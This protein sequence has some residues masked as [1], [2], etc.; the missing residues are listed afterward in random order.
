MSEIKKVK[1]QNI[2]ESQ[3]PEFLNEE[4]PLFKE[5]LEQYYLSLEYDTGIVNLAERIPDYKN[6]ENIITNEVLFNISTPCV[7]SSELTSFSQTIEVNHTVGFPERWGLLKIDDEIITY[8]SKTQNAFLGCQRGFSGLSLDN[9]EE[10]VFSKTESKEH[11]V[12][13]KVLNIS[14]Q[15]ASKLFD[16][17]RYQFLPGFNKNEFA[18]NLNISSILSY[19][20]EFYRTKGTEVSY[21]VLFTVLFGKDS[22]IIKPI[23]YMFKASS[24]EYLTT[25]NILVENIF[26]KNVFD[27]KGKTIFQLNDDGVLSSASVYNVEFRG[28]GNKEFYEL[29]LDPESVIGNLQSTKNTF[30]TEPSPIGS[31]VINVDSTLGFSIASTVIVNSNRLSSPFYLNYKEKT[32]NQFHQVDSIPYALEYGDSIIQSNLAYSYLDD[33]TTVQFRICNSISNLDTEKTY[34]L[35]VDDKI[36]VL[37]LGKSFDNKPE[38]LNWDYN[39]ALNGAPSRKVSSINISGISTLRHSVSDVYV[40]RSEENVYVVSTG[41]P[42]YLF[43]ANNRKFEL[44]PLNTGGQSGIT[45]SIFV[46]S[47]NH[48]LETGERLY[49]NGSTN[50]GIQTGYYFVTKNS[51]TSLSLSFSNFDV[52]QKQYVN[53]NK[54]N[55][56]LNA[57]RSGYEDTKSQDLSKKVKNQ[58]LLKKI[59][60]VKRESSSSQQSSIGNKGIGILR[61]GVELYS[62]TVLDE[63]IY[64]GR[65]EDISIISEGKDYDVINYPNLVITS[66]EGS[67]ASAHVNIIGE[68]K[69]VKVISPGIGFLEKP[70]ISIRGGNGEGAVLEA[71]FVKERIVSDFNAFLGI[72]FASNRI[73]FLNTHNF[74]D[75]EEII[76]NNNT[77][78]EIFPLRKDSTYFVNAISPNTLTLHNNLLDSL[79]GINTV[80]ITGISTGFH[81]LKSVESKNTINKIYVKDGGNGYSNKFVVINSPSQDNIFDSFNFTG[82]NIYDNELIVKNHT[83]KTGDL[84]YYSNNGTAISGITSTKQYIVTVLD[85]ERFKLSDAGNKNSNANK[86]D[87]IAQKYVSISGV[88]TG[89][90][91]FYY[92]PVE[93]VVE[94]LT[95]I[96]STAVSYPN[97]IPIVLGSIES[98][99]VENPGSGYGSPTILNFNKPP[100]VEV[101]SPTVPAILKPVLNNGSIIDVQIIN[102]GSGYTNDIYIEVLGSGQYAELIPNVVD[103]KIGSVLI[104]STGVGYDLKT[105]LIIRKRGSGAKFFANI[106]EWTVNQVVK[107]KNILASKDEGQGILLPSYNE[108]YGLEYANF[109]PP[110]LLRNS[111]NDNGTAHSPILGWS[112]DGNPIYGPFGYENVNGSG[113][114]KKLN[115]G[116]VL[117]P[118]TNLINSKLRPQFEEGY[119]VQDYQYQDGPDIDLDENNGRFCITPDYP[120]GIY[121]YF[122]STVDAN[123]S[124]EQINDLNPQYPYIIGGNFKNLP[125]L[126]NFSPKFNQL[127]ID[128]NEL[129]LI[130][131]TYQY[132]IGN[133]TYEI[134]ENIDNVY[135]QEYN[136]RKV[137]S[138]SIDDIEVYESGDNY[139]VGDNLLID[140]FGTDGIGL[141]ASVGIIKGREI[142]SFSVG[143]NTFSPVSF[144]NFSTI[145]VGITTSPHGLINGEK[146]VISA[147][148]TISAS[149]L[150]GE[151]IVSIEQKSTNV[152][153]DVPPQSITGVTT[154]IQVNDVIGYEIDNYVKINNETLR[155]IDIIPKENKLIVNRSQSFTGIHTASISKVI[156]LPNKFTFEETGKISQIFRNK[157]LY[158]NPLETVGVGTTNGS[159][160]NKFIGIKTEF[161]SIVASR[162]SFVAINTSMIKVGDYISG[163]NIPVG[164]AVTSVGIGSIGIS[165]LHTYNDVG[166]TTFVL[167]VER[168]EYDNSVPAKSIYLPKHNFYTG[169]ELV[170][171]TGTP[172]IGISVF[173]VAG[174]NPF[175]L[176]NNQV[177]YAV[178]YGENYLGIS[179]IGFTSTTGI[180]TNYNSLYFAQ[181]LT[182]AGKDHSLSTNYPVVTANVENYYVSIQ[183]KDNHT[184]VSNDQISFDY[185][186]RFTEQVILR[187]DSNSKKVTSQLIQFDATS[188]NLTTN[189]IPVPENAFNTGDKVIYYSPTVVVVGGLI[190][191]NTYYV[192]KESKNKIK[193]CSSKFDLLLG[194]EINLTSVGAEPHSFAK[195]N[196]QI[197]ITKGNV[198]NFVIE[199][200]TTMKLGLFKDQGF[201]IK[202]NEIDYINPDSTYSLD[203]NKTTI[204]DKLYYTLIPQS[205]STQNEKKISTDPEVYGGNVITILSNDYSLGQYKVSV[206]SDKEFKINL[207]KK[208]NILA[209]QNVTDIKYTTNSKTVEGPIHDIK[210]NF[211]GRNYKKLPKI[212]GI[213]SKNGDGAVLL[214]V[215]GTIG[216]VDTIEAVKNSFDYPTDNTLLPLLSTPAVCEITNI[217]RIKNID[218]TY[219]GKNYNVPPRLKVIG[220]DDI[221][222]SAK[223]EGGSVVSVN[224]DKNT[225]NLSVPLDIVSLRNSNGYDIE[226]ITVGVG[227][228]TIVL[229][230]INSDNQVYPLINSGYGSTVVEFPFKVGDEIFIEKCRIIESDKS[231]YNSENYDNKFFRVTGIST[232]NYTVTFATDGVSNNFGTYDNTFGYGYVTKKSD[233]ATFKM[234]LI[235]DLSYFS[236]EKV[237]STNFEA[238][239]MNNGWDN[240]INELRMIDCKGS[241][242]D[243]DFLYGTKSKLNGKVIKVNQYEIFSNL[244]VYRDKIISNQINNS[245]TNDYLIRTSD[246]NYYQ[247]F[248]YS[249]KSEVPYTDW[250]EYIKALDHPAGFKEFSDLNI[251]SKPS[252]EVF[253]SGIG[254]S[255][256]LETKTVDLKIDT[257]VNID[258]N[259]SFYTKN[260]FSLV[261]EDNIYEDGSIENILIGAERANVVGVGLTAVRGVSLAPYIIN[262]TN[263]VLSIDDISNQFTGFTTTIGGKVVG[264]TSFK[265]KNN[266]I[267][268]FYRTFNSANSDV[269]TLSSNTIF[270]E[271]HN[272]QTGQKLI[273]DSKSGTK[274]GI[275]TTNLV[276]S[277]IVVIDQNGNVSV[278][279]TD[280][281]IIMQVGS[282]IGSAIYENGYNVGITTTISG[283]SSNAPIG[284][285]YA[286]FGS[287]SPFIPSQALTGIG[288][289]AKFTVLITY[290][291]TGSPLS[292]SII[293]RDGGSGYAVG[294]RVSIAGTYFY[295][296]NPANNLSFFVSKVSSTKVIGAANNVYSGVQG[297]SVTGVGTGVFFTVT[298]GADGSITKTTVTAGGVG[299]ALTDRIRILGSS[300]GGATPQDDYLFSPTVLG[301]NKLPRNV[302]VD[303]INNN[304]FKLSGISSLRLE[305]ELDLVSFG[306][307]TQSFEYAH[308][309]EST[310][311]LIDNIIQSP[312]SRRNITTTLATNVGIGSTVIYVSSGINSISKLDKLKINE[313]ILNVISVGIN[314]TNSIEVERGFLGSTPS[315]HSSGNLVTTLRGDFRIK[316]DVVYFSEAPYGPIGNTPFKINS[317]FQ[318]RVFSRSFDSL[319]YP[320]DQNIIL[321]DISVDFTGIAATNFVLKQNNSPVVGLFTD[322]NSNGVD[323]NNN[324]F[325]LINNVSQI[326]RQDFNIDTPSQ[327]TIRFISGVPKAG[328]IVSLGISS[329]F[330]YQTLSGAAATVSVSAAGT[331]S[332]VYLNGSGSGYRIAPIISVASTVGSGAQITATIGAGGTITNLSIANPGSGYTT[333][334][335]T[336]VNIPLPPNYSDLPLTYAPGNSGV[337]TGAKISVQVGTGSSVIQ[338]DIEEPGVGYKVG[339]VLIASGITTNP[340]ATS[341]TQF[342]LTVR[343]V[344]TDKFSGFYPGQFI[345]FED[346]S[347]FFNGRKRKFTLFYKINNIPEVI[348]LRVDDGGDLSL[349]KNL[350]VFFND[351]LQEPIRAYTFSGNRIIFTEPPKPNSKC[352]ILYYRGS[353]LDVST[354]EPTKTIKSGDGVQIIENTNDS[355]D[356]SQFERVVKKINSTSD[357]DTFTYDNVGI[358][359]D[360]NAPRPLR[361]IK[362]TKDRLINGVLYSKER[363]S[364]KSRIHPSTIA[365]K[366]I[367]ALDNEIY[368]QNAFPLFSDIDGLEEDSRDLKIVENREISPC[369]ATAFASIASSITSITIKDNGIGYQN[370]TSPEF[371][372]SSSALTIRDPINDWSP[373]LGISTFINLNAIIINNNNFYVA[374]GSQ[375]FIGIS[376]N[377]EKWSSNT[378][379]ASSGITYYSVGIT[380]TNRLI[381]VGSNGVIASS[382]GIGTTFSN[383]TQ[384]Q[385]LKPSDAIG[386]G[387]E[388]LEPDN[389]YNSTFKS[390]TYSKVLD[391]WSAVGSSGTAFSG[392]G[393]GTTQFVGRR[394]TQQTL[395][396]VTNNGFTFIVVG[397]SGYIGISN[398]ASSWSQRAFGLTS[399][400]LNKVIWDGNRFIAV[401]TNSTILVSSSGEIWESL[402]NLNKV[403]NFNNIQYY[404]EN[405]YVALDTNGDLYYT[406]DLINWELRKTD[407]LNDFVFNSNIGDYGR[408]VIVGAAG[409]SSYADPYYNRAT[410]VGSVTSGIVTSAQI[411]NGGFGYPYGSFPPVLVPSD[412]LKDETIFSTKIIGDY[413]SIIGIKTFAQGVAGIGTTLPRVEFQLKSN[414]YDN[415]NLGIGYSSINQFK[416]ANNNSITY[417][418]IG[419]GDY[420]VI[421]N[422]SS[423]V[424]NGFSLIGISTLSGQNEVIGVATNYI[425]GVY[426]AEAVLSNPSSGIVTVTCHFYPTLVYP[427]GAGIAPINVGVVSS[428]YYGDYSWSKIYGYQNRQR[429]SPQNFIVDTSNGLIGLTTSAQIYRTRQLK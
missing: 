201:T 130:R 216:R 224:I 283:I 361:W 347:Q 156:L 186:P 57:I 38:F 2:I 367:S 381:A 217:S 287:A 104:S 427:S 236:G 212:T 157:K 285:S 267:P 173:N 52:F 93:I 92:P 210:I 153:E 85:N 89:T 380:T 412:T 120:N 353:S 328:K 428:T 129:N 377:G 309:N 240:E 345:Q 3:I 141:N 73:N 406:F 259:E 205:N 78:V 238:T 8:T 273:Y 414:Y 88:G 164:T 253:S 263:K 223:I 378:I 159:I 74:F 348:T 218:I 392:V 199:N 308:S 63:S 84:V 96:G 387:E 307:G 207:N 113:E 421:S 121:A 191:K 337:G 190:D 272:Y 192:L 317:S 99:Q 151:K 50:S 339:D 55:Y 227:G 90:H 198:V 226:D 429:F 306:T 62:P 411:T 336:K 77:N 260:N 107:N 70:K 162:K 364:L 103:G 265:L 33:G 23:E 393:I 211:N 397:S 290:G 87:F 299:Y 116:Y 105:Q 403:I 72:D 425:D 143:I 292:T 376:T 100:L 405:L 138:S 188:V 127:E 374:V 10:F 362:Q 256:T 264:V 203:T 372:I 71:N 32:A 166:V 280:S 331:I 117:I 171:K 401:G 13:S 196:P 158:F 112:Y 44:S 277:S 302:Y 15:F 111:L 146:I 12:E 1:I 187:Y 402:Q 349:D 246:N 424:I 321:D 268:I 242:E 324:P 21:K 386:V 326:S 314:S 304:Q 144:Y 359:T 398:N 382:V 160:Y 363:P 360:L 311:I 286:V 241:L 122:Y 230:L 408:Y 167:K 7:L 384:I 184:L 351:I 133:N 365:I 354:I 352:N 194:K 61:N 181:P 136:V 350:F 426:R 282:G 86:E 202:L 45:T 257:L 390:I 53:F 208:P 344:F 225:N 248:S 168:L 366:S 415:L 49:L 396:S 60:V 102:S 9:N 134:L 400:S 193:L 245:L 357:F 343:E 373:C 231:N 183:T 98:I 22:E 300:I 82:I 413:G 383:W 95:G 297:T 335:I 16:K 368:V 416:D 275:K 239:V 172:G 247:N 369:I 220:R 389:A 346:I 48:Y 14:A 58:N 404:G 126:N 323:I 149:Y 80:N 43:S 81:T 375:D 97:L 229:E 310:L 255:T 370:T 64:Y 148:S 221:K 234:N 41:F 125:E 24:D 213:N 161:A 132:L 329:S 75:G 177:V 342:R 118:T 175:N 243:G 250:K 204:L 68:V 76:Y 232:A 420:F 222:L 110:D 219:S 147:A 137:L 327:N 423:R 407:N 340:K 262:K 316:E 391:T 101:S 154:Y 195:I 152:I 318:G 332:N 119:F 139:K 5:F 281:S 303:K 176:N 91:K 145:F 18:S 295:G 19:A 410:A 142:T 179:T 215:S 266:S 269:I 270:L 206:V 388:V 51:S 197:S 46:S 296:A 417:S 341:F 189:E 325:V 39:V 150:E 20:R 399:E 358:N 114:I 106:T 228:T 338:F 261:T 235:D 334:A 128:I 333:S 294:D 305:S 178:N 313:E 355:F 284:I 271:N 163:T 320:N 174:S 298:R 278:S 249:I 291:P 301:T 30:V 36:K 237:T 28:I 11:V 83:L 4:N 34:G 59:P 56:S 356:I 315:S 371:Y 252:E 251:N 385:K 6:V 54:G 214:P 418:Q 185:V 395:N 180:G 140:N 108:E 258:S 131:N 169:Q 29:A 276:E 66:D 379:N 170:Y 293:L 31:R 289:G 200:T 254:R 25:K 422:S 288:T 40:D 312:L 330:G 109:Y 94:A 165:Q 65:I 123:T 79:S 274:I 35:R 319:N 394:V 155:V 135:K 209:L 27:L 279:S 67:G 26:G 124:N 244:G 322:T 182:A 47:E 42:G 115:S 17:F 409:T 69:E 233:I 419:I 37:S